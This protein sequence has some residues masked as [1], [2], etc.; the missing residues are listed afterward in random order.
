MKESGFSRRT[1]P[2]ALLLGLGVTPSL[3]L[4]AHA[5]YDV[6]ILQ[7]VGGAATNQPNAISASGQSVGFSDTATGYDAVLWSPT[8][9]TTMLADPGGQGASAPAAIN[10]SGQ[11]VGASQ[12]VNAYEAVLWSPAGAATLLRS[13][14]G[15][16]AASQAD[17]INASG[18]SVGYAITSQGYDA[19]L[20]S[21]YGRPDPASRCR[22][23]ARQHSLRDQ[24]R[25]AKRRD[26][27]HQPP[28]RADRRGIVVVVG[29][30][31]RAPR[32]GRSGQ[33]RR[34]RHQR[35]RRKRRIFGNHVR[36]RGGAVVAEGNC[37]G[38]FRTQAA[39]ASAA[40]SLLTKPEG[41]LDFPR[42][43]AAR[44]RCC[45]PPQGTATV[46]K[47]PGDVGFADAVAINASGH[48]VGYVE[49][50]SGDE[51]VLWQPSG[52]ATNL[53][54]LLGPDWSNTQAVAINNAG[55]ILGYGE[56]QGGQYPPG[57]Y[58][59]LLTKDFHHGLLRCAHFRRICGARVFHIG[60]VGSWLCER[61]LRWLP[62]RQDAP[63][64]ATG[65]RIVVR[66]MSIVPADMAPLSSMGAER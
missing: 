61:W 26:F 41:A 11:S 47:D 6:T 16:G 66:S 46:L 58:G 25:R 29:G 34:R 53:D 24:C 64:V 35:V 38:R 57:E 4:T 63:G 8:G 7:D 37:D 55:D 21:S 12:T 20:W 28:T 50:T 49:T 39:R 43:L 22:R 5:A 54:G 30:R 1:Y 48:S 10:A 23:Q 14:S 9:V 33:K 27:L 59:F 62:S 18:Q 45:G 19:V 36:P 15:T 44:T 2:V 56:Y 40:P 51:A 65:T 32:C 42:P 13:P 31:D 17:D 3:A 60:Y 52:K